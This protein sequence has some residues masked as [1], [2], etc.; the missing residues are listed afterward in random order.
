MMFHVARCSF[1]VSSLLLC[2][3]VTAY[4]ASTLD[5]VVLTDSP[6]PGVDLTFAR[7]FLTSEANINDMGQVVFSG[8]LIGTGVDSTNNIGLWL[9]DPTGGVTQVAREGDSIPGR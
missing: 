6:A 7:F 4:G 2:V 9:F 3:A 5:T 1:L 8:E